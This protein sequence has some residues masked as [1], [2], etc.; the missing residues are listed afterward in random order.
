MSEKNNLTP[1]ECAEQFRW[2]AETHPSK[3]SQHSLRFCAIFLDEYCIQIEKSKKGNMKSVN[4]YLHN[5]NS[6]PGVREWM[7]DGND[8][9]H[10]PAQVLDT[11]TTELCRRF[12]EVKFDV[13]Y[14]ETTGKIGNITAHYRK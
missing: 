7:V 8:L 10:L 1:K 14:D 2:Y 5:T 12:Y 3:D 6:H 13:E 4:F 11:L 9:G